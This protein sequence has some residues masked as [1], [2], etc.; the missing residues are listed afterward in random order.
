SRGGKADSARR[1]T[2]DQH[3][4]VHGAVRCNRLREQASHGMPNHDWAAQRARCLDGIIHVVPEPHATDVVYGPA[5]VAAPEV[6]RKG[7]MPGMCEA[8]LPMLKAPRTCKD[9]MQ[10]EH[11]RSGRSL[12]THHRHGEP[13]RRMN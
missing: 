12:R 9:S 1:S 8:T 2:A 5:S 13:A 6:K 4:C 7:G 3:R 10:K 11:W